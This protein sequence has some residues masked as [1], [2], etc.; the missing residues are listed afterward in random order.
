MLPDAQGPEEQ[1]NED[2]EAADA[3]TTVNNLSDTVQH[4]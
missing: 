4:A 2:E 1:K 3:L